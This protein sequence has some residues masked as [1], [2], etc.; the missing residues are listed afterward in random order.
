MNSIRQR[1]GKLLLG[2]LKRNAMVHRPS[3]SVTRPYSILNQLP[4][5]RRRIITPWFATFL[6]GGV[7]LS[8]Y[9]GFI[10]YQTLTMWPPEVRSDLRNAVRAKHKG[11]LESSEQHFHRAW[12]T[13]QTLPIDLLGSQPYLKLTGMAVALADVLELSNK[14]QNAYDV[15]VHALK[16]LQQDQ[17]KAT[18]TGPERLRAVAISSKLGE[19]AKELKRSKT[20]EEKWLVWAVEELLRIVKGPSKD[21]SSED[22]DYRHQGS[23]N[24]PMLALPSWI[25]KT[26]IG[27]PLE[28]LGSFYAGSGRL[29][30]A[31]PLYLQAI[32]LLI[33]P[34]PK[35]ST[36]EDRCRGAQLMGNLSE[37]IMRGA[38]TPE[39]LH[40]AEAWASQALAVTK[41]AR[42]DASKPIVQ[43]EEVYAAALFNVATF[44]DMAGDKKVARSLYRDGLEHARSIG[45]T[46]GVVEASRALHRLDMGDGAEVKMS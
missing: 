4:P 40:Q 31:M 23:F 20:E 5:A 1:A 34:A 18:L 29:D 9:G 26:D 39:T 19:L 28:A 17:V 30:F 11:D 42:A 3:L 41:K 46:E 35:K 25:S 13:I 45:M 8:G 21:D 22:V 32:S 33:P 14:K 37:M 36:P 6:L 7:V 10:L 15:Y 16:L 44:R 24:L 43:C 12:N 38:P 27:A 2:S